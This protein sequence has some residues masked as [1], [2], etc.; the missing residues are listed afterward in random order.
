MDGF[1]PTV[2]IIDT[3]ARSYVGKNENDPMDAG[4]WVDNA[5]KLRHRGMTILVLHHTRK[6]IEFGLKERGTTAWMGAM[7]SAYTLMRNPDGFKNYAKLFC[8]KQKDHQE[9]P[10]IWMQHEQIRPNPEEEGSIVLLEVEPPGTEDIEAKQAEEEALQVI[11]NSLL[12][13]P[14]FTSDRARARALSE[15]AGI[16][17]TTAQ[18]RLH[19]ARKKEY[20]AK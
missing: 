1:N 8:T 15:K 17:E 14:T 12:T 16:L 3:L 13:D 19:R 7:D 4:I 11:I 10:D 18:S 6:N 9:P 5:D 20:S 2:M